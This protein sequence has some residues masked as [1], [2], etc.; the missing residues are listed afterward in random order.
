MRIDEFFYK[1]P[2]IKFVELL[3]SPLHSCAP[4]H[5]ARTVAEAGEVSAFGANV[6]ECCQPWRETVRTAIDDYETFL[7]AAN[8]YGDKFPIRILCCEGYGEEDYKISVDETQCVIRSSTPEGA[9]RAIYYLE[10]EMI[11][12]EGAFLPLGDIIRSS[13]IKRRITRG[14]FSPTN[15]APKCLI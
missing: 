13:R 11:K 3:N 9:R 14:Y 10:E 6:A 12:R 2:D 8:V 15:R 1:Q 7:R 4:K 5:F